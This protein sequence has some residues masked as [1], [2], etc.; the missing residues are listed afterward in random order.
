MYFNPSIERYVY[1]ITNT[2]KARQSPEHHLGYTGL[3]PARDDGTD[4]LCHGHH[5][6]HG[7]DQGDSEENKQQGGEVAEISEAAMLMLSDDEV[8]IKKDGSNIG[9]PNEGVMHFG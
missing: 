5:Y 8:E 2:E 7:E 9:S 6:K 4:E 3:A 1:R